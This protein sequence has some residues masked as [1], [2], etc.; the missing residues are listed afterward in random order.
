MGSINHSDQISS[1]YIS[2]ISYLSQYN[3]L[4]NPLN[5]NYIAALNGYNRYQADSGFSYMDLGCGDGTT[6]NMLALLF[7][8]SHFTGID[9]N[10]GHI[11]S[12]KTF[13]AR[14]GICNVEFHLT[15]FKDLQNNTFKLSDYIVCFGTFSWINNKLQEAICDFV[16]KHLNQNGLFLVHYAAR[17][18]KV[19]IDPL[20]HLMRS[21]PGDMFL[22]ST[23][24]VRHGMSLIQTLRDKGS[25]FFRQNPLAL[26]RADALHGQD[27][28]Y[29]AHEALS[30]WQAF[31]HTD[32]VNRMSKSGLS[33][34]GSI[35]P[36]DNHIETRVPDAFHDLLKQ[37]ELVGIE[38]TIIDYILNRGVRTDLFIKG[39][40]S[41]PET[42]SSLEK[43]PFGLL[44]ID[45]TFHNEY[46]C[47]TGVKIK[48]NREI[49]NAIL[50]ELR[51]GSKTIE[52]LYKARKTSCFHKNEIL[53]SVCMLVTGKQIKP[54]ARTCNIKRKTPITRLKPANKIIH[55]IL[56]SK[57]NLDYIVYLPH[58][59]Y[60]QCLELEPIIA[61]I[62]SA[63]VYKKKKGILHWLRQQL[64]NAGVKIQAQP[65]QSMPVEQ[66]E[67]L[68]QER[69]E[70]VKQTVIPT[71]LC[72][73]ILRQ[74]GE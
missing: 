28:N 3:P 40:L 74:E 34:T 4:L 7:P 43:I 64:I 41:E 21:I 12:A 46:A 15:D 65:L 9:F 27:V 5:I 36:E 20:W 67:L 11:K 38:E 61:L 33:F 57:I 52:E 73:G 22:N 13:A 31:Y 53:K 42:H 10:E 54:F 44:N 49:Y 45:N 32:I 14:T 19:Q 8:D 29:V 62:V 30:E 18:G 39:G 71:L 2:D 1:T 6:L 70:W 56:S 55:D 23:E 50:Q 25:L 51:N 16:S 37:T 63:L 35:N 59:M 48:Y 58:H 66:L 24:R 26:I 60:G 72:H 47:S 69:I 17:P 68:L